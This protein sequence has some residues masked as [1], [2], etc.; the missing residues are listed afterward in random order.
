MKYAI[1][2]FGDSFLEY[3]HLIGRIPAAMMNNL[4]TEFERQVHEV[5]NAIFRREQAIT[6]PG[7]YMVGYDANIIFAPDHVQDLL[8]VSK[9][10]RDPMPVKS[11]SHS[12]GLCYPD[13]TG[14]SQ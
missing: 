1:L 8:P 11:G 10:E 5:D 6:I 14:S 3:L 12:G 4:I 13:N 2:L 9:V 7:E